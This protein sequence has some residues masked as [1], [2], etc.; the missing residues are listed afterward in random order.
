MKKRTLVAVLM[1]V[2][3]VSFGQEETEK[4]VEPLDFYLFGGTNIDPLGDKKVT[5][6]S[7][8]LIKRLNFSDK[9]KGRFSLYTNKN[10]ISDSVIFQTRYFSPDV[11]NGLKEGES[12]IYTQK[13]DVSVARNIRAWGGYF[14]LMRE[15]DLS[16]H[17]SISP[18]FGIEFTY[19][20]QTG[21][22][23]IKN[24]A[25]IDS[26]VYTKDFPKDKVIS[27]LPI[28]SDRTIIPTRKLYQTFFNFGVVFE[29]FT[30]NCEFYLQPSVGFASVFETIGSP[31]NRAIDYKSQRFVSLRGMIRAVP[32][33]IIIAG[34]LK[35][36]GRGNLFFNMSIGLPIDIA[37]LVKK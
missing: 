11:K 9:V 30:K 23:Q 6:A 22:P 2:A 7:F 34:D 31:A 35:S 28:T 29:S 15:F 12:T 16:N 1:L 13:Y 26:T 24:S 25:V 19:R 21:A 32:S 3:S 27:T 4:I 17:T 8:E 5:S 18:F 20:E 37:S 10:A 14:N 36:F 33:N